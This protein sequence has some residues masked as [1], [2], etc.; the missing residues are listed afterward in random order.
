MKTISVVHPSS[1]IRKGLT[2][3]VKRYFNIELNTFRNLNEFVEKH[4]NKGIQLLFIYSL[5][6]EEARLYRQLNLH[7]I[8]TICLHWPND[9]LHETTFAD[10]SISLWAPDSAY[11]E[12]LKPLLA[13]KEQGTE[14]E[15]KT[16]LT[17]REREV[18][19]EVALG[20]SNKEAANKL[21]ISI[22]TVISHRKNITEKL[23]IKSIS[24]LTVYAIINN[25]ID[26]ET[27]DPQTLI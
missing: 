21:N 7:E 16:E 10:Y 24:G 15:T 18:L 19:K 6:E 11:Y 14:L 4:D 5:N 8:T 22:H 12:L 13:K 23:G 20:L 26:T 1:I 25:L 3:L 2:D 27:I 17:V 9:G